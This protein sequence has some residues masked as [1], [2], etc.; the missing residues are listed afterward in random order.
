MFEYISALDREYLR[1]ILES[2]DYVP[3]DTENPPVEMPAEMRARI[4]HFY[5]VSL[6]EEDIRRF[7]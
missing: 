1:L 5:M 3:S 2:K 7:E 4:A 6:V